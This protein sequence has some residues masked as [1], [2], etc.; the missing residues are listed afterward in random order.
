MLIDSVNSRC[1]LLQLREHILWFPQLGESGRILDL[2]RV[3][4]LLPI[5]Q[6]LISCNDEWSLLDRQR[7]PVFT[8]R[9]PIF[10][11]LLELGLAAIV[12]FRGSALIDQR[13]LQGAMSVA[14][15]LMRQ[16][17]VPI[18]QFLDAFI[19]IMEV[20]PQLRFELRRT[21]VVYVLR[22]RFLERQGH[23]LRRPLTRSHLLQ[24]APLWRKGV[25]QIELV[26]NQRNIGG[27]VPRVIFVIVVFCLKGGV[28]AGRATVLLGLERHE[29]SLAP[30]SLDL[31]VV[32][33]ELAR[34]LQVIEAHHVDRLLHVLVNIHILMV[35][36]RQWQ[37]LVAAQLALD[38][39]R[40]LPRRAF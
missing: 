15:I 39:D 37:P 36:E 25:L 2:M 7:L 11:L 17:V 26:R 38:L 6:N 23:L 9:Y 8:R 30:Q 19:V 16:K 28:L 40:L 5:L 12:P 10:I 3:R 13:K 32:L 4:L 20:L 35:A 1:N 34:V 22:R 18:R 24:S 29:G 21:S 27:F 14:S 33:G 31:P